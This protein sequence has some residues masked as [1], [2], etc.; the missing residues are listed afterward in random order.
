MIDD[1]DYIVSSFQTQY[2]IRLEEELKYLSTYEFF[3]YL[4]G[5]NEDTALVK[6][7]QIRCEEDPERLKHFTPQ[8]KKQRQEWAERRLEGKTE[9][10]KQKALKADYEELRQLLSGVG[11]VTTSPRH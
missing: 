11:E 8:M 6:L 2:H 4:A 1:W 7:C 3:C 9:N 5:L 10:E